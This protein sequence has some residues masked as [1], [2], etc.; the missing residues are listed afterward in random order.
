MIVI[1]VNVTRDLCNKN[2]NITG[3]ASNLTIYDLTISSVYV[4]IMGVYSDAASKVEWT[5][6]VARALTFDKFAAKAL[7]FVDP[8][9]TA[10]YIKFQI[11]DYA[12]VYVHVSLLYQKVDS[13]SVA[14][15]TANVLFDGLGG[16][17]L[18]L[19]ATAIYCSHPLTP[20]SASI[21]SMY[22]YKFYIE[23][24]T[25]FDFGMYGRTVGQLHWFLPD[26]L[27]LSTMKLSSN[28]GNSRLLDMPHSLSLDKAVYLEA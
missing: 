7:V 10:F 25:N 22:P 15:G 12:G 14:V 18:E 1:D 11:N 4:D 3:T 17:K 2:W 21:G 23:T 16:G 24:Y 6:I 27:Q 20:S 26:L 13:I 19:E 8:L 9:E 5:S 28:H